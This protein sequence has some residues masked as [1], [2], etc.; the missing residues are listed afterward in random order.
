MQRQNQVRGNDQS[1]NASSREENRAGQEMGQD[2][3][4]P[5][6]PPKAQGTART[7]EPHDAPEADKS[8]GRQDD[9]A[10]P[11]KNARGG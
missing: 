10:Q 1:G 5:H 6:D 3:G 9:D 4:K 8:R 7:P 11:S 2:H